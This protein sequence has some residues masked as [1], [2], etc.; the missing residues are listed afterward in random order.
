MAMVV[1]AETRRQAQGPVGGQVPGD[2][3]SEVVRGIG[4]AEA[5][6]VAEAAIHFNSGNEIFTAEVTAVDRSLERQRTAG[7]KGISELPGIA[8]GEVLHCQWIEGEVPAI[9]RAGE[10]HLDLEFMIVSLARD[11]IGYGVVR[12]DIVAFHFLDNLVGFADLLVLEV[13]Y[14]VDEV[15]TLEQ[16]QAILPAEAS[17]DCAVVESRLAIE[18][19]LGG[20]PGGGSV[21]ELGPEGDRKSV[22]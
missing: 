14:R 11:G 19:E 10:Q 12:L 9:V 6:A 13:E 22:V 1:Q 7:P 21:F 3:G 17:E 20:P 4:Q 5:V 18:V 8:A 15:L 16:A 2:D